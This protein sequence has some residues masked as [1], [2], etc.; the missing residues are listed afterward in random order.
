MAQAD[1]DDFGIATRL[2]SAEKKELAELRREK[3]WL[4]QEIRSSNVQLPSLL[5]RMYSQRDL[6]L[7]RELAV[8]GIY[9]AVVCPVLQVSRSAI[10]TDAPARPRRGSRRSCRVPQSGSIIAFS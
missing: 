3:H 4:E 10:T 7:V 6:R 9:V 1:A 5:G 2:T 8:D